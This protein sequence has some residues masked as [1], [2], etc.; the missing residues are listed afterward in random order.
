MGLLCEGTYLVNV[1]LD[2]NAHLHHVFELL[3]EVGVEPRQVRVPALQLANRRL[4]GAFASAWTETTD[5]ISLGY[6]NS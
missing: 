4:Q 2:G 1:H 3:L 5:Q 6:R